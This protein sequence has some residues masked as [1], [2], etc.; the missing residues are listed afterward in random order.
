MTWGSTSWDIK[1]PQQAKPVKQNWLP[2]QESNRYFAPS[3]C[4]RRGLQKTCRPG[5]HQPH[6][7]QEKGGRIDSALPR[8]K[9]FSGVRSHPKQSPSFGNVT[10]QTKARVSS[11]PKKTCKHFH[12]WH[13]TAHMHTYV[14]H[15]Q[16]PLGIHGGLV[17][18][19]TWYQNLRW[20]KSLI[21][22]YLIW[23]VFAYNLRTS[24]YIL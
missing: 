13:W 9:S 4:S 20:R 23:K 8:K 10:W 21:Y 1:Q 17:S 2:E 14:I 24:S 11:L 19:P 6:R 3:H 12:W 7:G 16:S 15:I 18:G 5:S 22:K